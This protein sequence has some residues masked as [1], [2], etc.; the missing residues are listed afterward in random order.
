MRLSE[1]PTQA[2]INLLFHPGTVDIVN[3]RPDV[4]SIDPHDTINRARQISQEEWRGLKHSPRFNDLFRTVF[5]D[6]GL[7]DQPLQQHGTGVQ[8][9]V[10]LLVLT[11]EAMRAGKTPF[12]RNPESYLHPTAQL[13][14]GDLLIKL[15]K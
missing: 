6:L 8:H 7:P 3:D 5:G 15:S 13:G 14:L 9:V 10:G 11:F 12:W 2:P 4:V 1:V